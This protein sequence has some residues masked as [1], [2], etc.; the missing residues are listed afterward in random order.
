MP[1]PIHKIKLKLKITYINH[2]HE[3][4]AYLI[5]IYIPTLTHQIRKYNNSN[6]ICE[7]ECKVQRLMKWA[8]L[9]SGVF[10]RLVHIYMSEMRA[11]WIIIIILIDIT[12]PIIMIG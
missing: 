10:W 12:A 9:L 3:S 6:A 1:S 8:S 7:S 4:V 11:I 5:N 2:L